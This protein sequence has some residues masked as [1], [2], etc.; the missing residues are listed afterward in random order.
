MTERVGDLNLIYSGAFWENCKKIK[1]EL[2][3]PKKAQFNV[4]RSSW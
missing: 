3:G 2:T 1:I 4:F